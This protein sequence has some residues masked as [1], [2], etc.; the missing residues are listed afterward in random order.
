M[1]RWRASWSDFKN[2]SPPS[3]KGMQR[4]SK[5]PL[6]LYFKKMRKMNSD[7]ARSMHPNRHFQLLG[8]SKNLWTCQKPPKLWFSPF[9]KTSFSMSL[10]I[11]KKIDILDYSSRYSIWPSKCLEET[12][13]WH[14][15]QKKGAFTQR[16]D[17]LSMFSSF[18]AS[19]DF[20]GTCCWKKKD[21]EKNRLFRSKFEEKRSV[22]GF[23][24]F[25]VDEILMNGF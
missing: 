14:K 19:V 8:H 21:F 18:V 20:V 2:P 11:P 1:E 6:K 7:I 16:I 9:L 5:I 25:W 12:Q 22:L 23:W 24:T 4:V 10:Y 13:D 3:L 15:I 17:S